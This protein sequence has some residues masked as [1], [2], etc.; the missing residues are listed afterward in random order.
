MMEQ[1]KGRALL[2]YEDSMLSEAESR[3]LFAARLTPHRSLTRRNFHLLMMVFSGAS[4]FS[5]LPFILLG[6][7]PVAGFMGLDVALFYFAF[8]AN[9]RAARAYEDVHVTP[10]ELLLAKV[11]ARGQ[12]AEWRFNPVWVR[13]EREEHAEFGTQRLA[14][15][16]RGK[17]VELAAFLGPEE[18]ADFA[19]ALARALAEARR[20]PRFS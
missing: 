3:R 18:K 7:W 8:R 5:S 20:G 1:K 17:S 2:S 19:S 14:L 16:S 15:V 4:L 10:F 12:R 9:F 13:L 6:A 11:S